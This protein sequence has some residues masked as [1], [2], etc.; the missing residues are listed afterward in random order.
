[1]GE[2]TVAISG[3]ARTFAV[4]IGLAA[5]AALAAVGQGLRSSPA[6]TRAARDTAGL[7][8]TAEDTVRQLRGTPQR[9]THV[10]MRPWG[11]RVRTEDAS[12]AA[13]HDGGLVVFDCSGHVSHVWLD[14][15]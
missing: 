12:P 4:V 3:K 10:R 7:A 9:V 1:V 6:C 11:V 2:L 13:L 14:G 15:G 8:R 5:A